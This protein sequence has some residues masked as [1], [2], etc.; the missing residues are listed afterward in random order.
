LGSPTQHAINPYPS[1][2]TAPAL[3]IA[4]SVVFLWL[5]EL[6]QH[7]SLEKEV[8]RYLVHMTT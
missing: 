1:G 8:K 2:D 6:Q 4:R 3:P 7:F 5:Q